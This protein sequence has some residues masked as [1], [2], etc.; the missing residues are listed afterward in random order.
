MRTLLAVVD[1]DQSGAVQSAAIVALGRLDDPSV[2]P[3][4]LRRWPRLLPVMR[5]QVLPVLLARPDRAMALVKAVESGAVLRNE[6][7]PTQTAFLMAH[8]SADVRAAAASVFK[9]AA[10]GDRRAV[11]QRYLAAARSPRQQRQGSDDVSGAVCVVPRG[12]AP[13]AARLDRV[14]RPSRAPRGKRS[15]RICSIPTGRSMRGTASISSK[16]RTGEA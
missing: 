6:L 9:R 10:E 16:R 8:R 1:S 5:R 12:R 13:T 4:L 11:V 3:E 14:S 7:T 15:S 2:A